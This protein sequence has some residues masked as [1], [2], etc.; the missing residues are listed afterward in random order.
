M[1]E[2]DARQQAEEEGKRLELE[3]CAAEHEAEGR[4]MTYHKVTKTD[5]LGVATKEE[6]MRLGNITDVGLEKTLAKRWCD[7]ND[8]TLGGYLGN[9]CWDTTK[10]GLE[11]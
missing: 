2:H 9:G 11:K 5:Y 8:Y 7:A 10:G 4:E 1:T 6:K 3:G